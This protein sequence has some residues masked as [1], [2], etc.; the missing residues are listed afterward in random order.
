MEASKPQKAGDNAKLVSPT[1]K[2]AGGRCL[3]F[4]YHMHG[5]HIGTL[6]V[7]LQTGAALVYPVWKRAGTQGDRWI[8]ASVNVNRTVQYKVRAISDYLFI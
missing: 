6:N 4:W 1:L 3:E 8:K 2:P 7:Y 5:A